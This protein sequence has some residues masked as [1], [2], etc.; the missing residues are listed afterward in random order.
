[1]FDTIASAFLHVLMHHK[2]LFFVYRL[3]SSLS[4]VELGV[5]LD[6]DVEISEL[7]CITEVRDEACR[8]SVKSGTTIATPP[9]L[10][11]HVY[12]A[13]RHHDEAFFSSLNSEYLNA[14][15]WS[16]IQY[17]VVKVG[18]T[19]SALSSM[20]GPAVSTSPTKLGSTV[21]NYLTVK[22]WSNREYLTVKS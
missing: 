14:K 12:I 7:E 22:G 18:P 3:L 2:S 19:A 4:L 21:S 15:G 1:M 11:L 8:K 13:L 16:N 20:A 9:R 6:P 17:L 10:L 5:H